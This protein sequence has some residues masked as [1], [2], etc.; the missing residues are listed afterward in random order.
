MTSFRPFVLTL[1][2]DFGSDLK[3]QNITS[4]SL[5]SLNSQNSPPLPARPNSFLLRAQQQL[6]NQAQSFSSSPLNSAPNS[7]NL[8]QRSSNIEAVELL[9]SQ[10]YIGSTDGH[11]LVY[12]FSSQTS[13]STE[14]KQ[15][16]PLSTFFLAADSKFKFQLKKYLGLGRKIIERIHAVPTENKLLVLCDGTLFFFSLDSLTQISI[17]P[18]RGVTSFCSD[19]LIAS[20]LNIS[21]AK[22]RV[23]QSAVLGDILQMEKDVSLPDGAVTMTRHQNSVCV[24]DQQSYKMGECITLFNYERLLMRPL[25]VSVGD[26]EFLLVNQQQEYGLGIFVNSSGDAVRGTLQWPAV[27]RS[28]STGTRLGIR[29]LTEATYNLEMNTSDSETSTSIRIVVNGKDSLLGLKMLSLEGQINELFKLGQVE[30]AVKLAENV[31]QTQDENEDKMEKL[32]KIHQRAGLIFFKETQFDDALVYF[33]KGMINPK[34]F[35]NLFPTISQPEPE[36]ISESIT[37]DE[38]DEFEWKKQFGT[39]DDIVA[40]N[41]K[42]NYP[43]ADSETLQSFALALV[44]NARVKMERV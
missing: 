31:L 41:L 43:G 27:P 6:S 7:P 2:A 29:S 8:N 22:R 35:I 44:D 37:I 38:D 19:L 3:E 5:D 12:L 26:G 1:L 16:V 17:Q 21:F 23:L 9:D 28:V 10:L 30:K 20:P 34:L 15:V 40:T 4:Q 32:L 11:L 13:T 33:K 42:R 14:D 18:I 24:A 36:N 39:V 25:I